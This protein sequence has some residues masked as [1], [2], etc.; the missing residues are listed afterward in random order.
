MGRTILRTFVGF[1]AGYIVYLPAIPVVEIAIYGRVD[2]E[3]AFY[4]LYYAVGAPFLLFPS[5]WQ[6]I[7]PDELVLN[8]VG[9][10]LIAI[11]IAAANSRRGR[12]LWVFRFL[13]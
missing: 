3:K 7:Q 5:G 9:L 10:A 6:Y 11:G 4:A 13:A 2:Q 12:S 1:I 8:L